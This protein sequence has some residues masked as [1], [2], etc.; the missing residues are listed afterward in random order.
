MDRQIS[1]LKNRKKTDERKVNSLSD[2][3]DNVKPY[4]TY[5]IEFWKERREREMGRKNFG[6]VITEN[7]QIW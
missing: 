7:F 2:P 6:E 4:N 1:Y 5:V 3:G